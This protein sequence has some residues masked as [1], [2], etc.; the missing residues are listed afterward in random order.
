M[1][2]AVVLPDTP[3]SSNGATIRDHTPNYWPGNTDY[4]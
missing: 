2:S 4:L 3:N 1:Q